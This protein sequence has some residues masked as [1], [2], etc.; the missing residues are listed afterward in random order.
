VGGTP[1]RTLLTGLAVP[2]IGAGVALDLGASAHTG[3]AVVSERVA[4]VVGAGSEVARATAQILAGTG[5]R[6]VGIDRNEQR[7][8][9]LT[10][11]VARE[12]GD[13]DRSGRG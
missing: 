7:L 3:G 6:V 5:Y 9:E 10:D 2:V 12:Q 8:K 4:I 1:A 13:P 11:G